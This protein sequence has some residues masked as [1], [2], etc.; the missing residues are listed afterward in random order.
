MYAAGWVMHDTLA[1]CGDACTSTRFVS[2]LRGLGRFTVP[3]GALAGPVDF[4]KSQA[5]LTT[6]QLWSWDATT[7]KS[8]GK[9]ASFPI[10]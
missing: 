5:G 2:S 9:G 7:R 10:V 1:K 4:S 6:A 3:N 8:V